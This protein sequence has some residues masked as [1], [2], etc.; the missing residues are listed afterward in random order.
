MQATPFL[1]SSPH[2][3]VYNNSF[4]YNES[5]VDVRISVVGIC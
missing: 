4:F 1:N 3:V 2:T 5:L